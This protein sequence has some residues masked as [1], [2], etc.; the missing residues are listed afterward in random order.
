MEGLFVGICKKLILKDKSD[1][2]RNPFLSNA[3]LAWHRAVRSLQVTDELIG[4]L[5]LSCCCRRNR[6]RRDHTLF[7]VRRDVWVATRELIK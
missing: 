4:Q 3:T 6:L 7:K 5:H 1:K 2:E